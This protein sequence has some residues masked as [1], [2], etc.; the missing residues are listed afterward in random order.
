MDVLAAL[1][2]AQAREAR[3]LIIAATLATDMKVR[4]PRPMGAAI[5][6]DPPSP[7]PTNP[8]LRVVSGGAVTCE[9]GCGPFEVRPEAPQALPAPPHRARRTG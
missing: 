6:A 4:R 7:N 1:P 9:S 8:Q 3:R 5:Q 2:A